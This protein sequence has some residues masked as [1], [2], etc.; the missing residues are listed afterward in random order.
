MARTL[1]RS[2]VVAGG[3]AALGIVSACTL[4]GPLDGYAEGLAPSGSD[5]GN[6][7]SDASDA[8]VENQVEADPCPEGFGDCDDD[9]SNGCETALATDLAHCGAC[10]TP[11]VVDHGQAACVGGVCQVAS[12]DQGYDDCDDLAPT[13]C[14]A[15]L[16]GA[17]HC[18]SC[19]NVC[20]F[21]NAQSICDQGTCHL[22]QCLDGYGDCDD[23]AGNGCEQDTQTS[24]GHCGGCGKVCSQRPNGTP[25]CDDGA[26]ALDCTSGYGDCDGDYANG[27]EVVL[28]SDALH[29]GAC[30]HPC[31]TH[32]AVPACVSG[33]CELACEVGFDDCDGSV[34][35]GCE[36]ELQT[37]PQHCGA[38]GQ[39]CPSGQGAVPA[40]VS[41]TCALACSSG[42]G[43][44]N[45]S[46]DDGC[47]T[48]LATDSLHCGTCGR[49]C[50]GGACVDGACLVEQLAASLNR[51]SGI[52][53][54]AARVYWTDSYDNNVYSVAKGGGAVQ[55][56]ATE[57]AI[58][59][60]ALHG[61]TLYWATGPAIARIETNGTGKQ[62]V[63]GGE[64][65]IADL[66]HD[67]TN[68]YWLRPGTW[69]GSTYNQ[70]GT[71]ARAPMSGGA[72]VP[73][74]LSQK[75][76][77]ALA[78]DATHVFWVNEGSYTGMTYNND[79]SVMRVA[80][81]G[82]AVTTLANAQSKP[83][84]IALG[85]TS[86][87]WTNCGSGVV[88]AM[89]KVGGASEVLLQGQSISEGLRF[90]ATELFWPYR[91]ANPNLPTGDVRKAWLGSAQVLV[92]GALQTQPFRLAVDAQHV[93]WLNLGG[94]GD[95]PPGNGAV[96]RV[97]R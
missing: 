38:C 65:L 74:A 15:D 61:T 68:L 56:V 11:C 57:G 70:D 33:A 49:S 24:V 45:G 40:C 84:G 58:G 95:P 54:D 5:A 3:V 77:K 17:E 76:P 85:D 7:A 39:G 21:D 53:V 26:C 97:P 50:L 80:K 93:Y 20:A 88:M 4:T 87:Y 28:E 1:D 36:A 23:N 86:V 19:D 51:P 13:G 2:A 89:P 63:V 6:D 46:D 10:D 48:N 43:D 25:L 44:C 42:L 8:S 18:G 22:D 59:P 82:G 29:C 16:A 73:L 41:G 66:T 75:Q 83:C 37:D 52:V 79:G 72:A 91:G 78:V 9:V 34:D 96:M 62:N 31:S 14:E 12:C 60:I 90:D 27:C 30:G 71:L 69:S 47:E 92:V 64:S 81:S 67:G 35:T 94:A 32:N 55:T